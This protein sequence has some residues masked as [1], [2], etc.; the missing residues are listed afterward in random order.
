MNKYFS[1][2]AIGLLI[3]IC[4]W[5]GKNINTWGR[6][7]V[8]VHDVISYYAY[9]PAAV[10]F[11][12]LDFKFIN[13][14][15]PEFQGKIWYNN[16]PIGKPV[17]RMTLG[18]AILWMPFFLLGHILAL[19]LGVAAFGYSWPY[20]LSI[21]V[22]TL[23]YLAIGLIFLRKI[24]LKYF[25]DW[26]IAI[27]LILI[28]AATNLMYYVI[29]EPGMSHV[30]SFAMVTIF[31][32]STLKWID[33]PTIFLSIILGLLAGLIVLIRPVN[34]LVLLFPALLGINS[35]SGI[36]N[37]VV[38][39]WKFIVIAAVSCFL[40]ILPQII[41]W[42]M[43]TGQFLFNSYQESNKFY[44]LQPHVMSGLLGFRKGWLIYTPVMFFA[45]AG[46]FVVE[47]YVKGFKNALLAFLVIFI[48]VIFSWWCWWYGG[49]FGSRPMIEAYGILAVPLAASL[50]FLLQRKIWIKVFTGVI[51][52]AFI[53]L[54]QFQMGQ[55]RTSLLHWDSMTKKTYMAIFLKKRTPAGYDKI[56]ERPDYKKAL[57]GGKE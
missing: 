11:H 24:L 7:T 45:L 46:L 32:F 15:R 36:K 26:I 57:Q 9:L 54:N 20:S 42:K 28:V 53:Y 44:F 29:S 49:S 5:Y 43:Q 33:K 27:T 40:M 55:Y 6:D 47:K 39:N 16:S 25:P 21:F 48:Y 37:R 50:A 19:I 14:H 22:A 4:A 56:I 3:I 51:L 35:F 12:D 10:I 8:I 31:L 18:L 2:I 34:G 17:L 41:Y 30:Y 23:F 13:D 38:N 1:K 52:A